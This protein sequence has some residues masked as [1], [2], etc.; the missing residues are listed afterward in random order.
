MG[1]L[2]LYC[3][4][5][6]TFTVVS[7]RVYK[8]APLMKTLD[9]IYQYCVELK[10]GMP[11]LCLGGARPGAEWQRITQANITSFADRE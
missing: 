6:P 8:I 7:F 5:P 3:F 9:D 4:F 2:N 10:L 11:L 1:H